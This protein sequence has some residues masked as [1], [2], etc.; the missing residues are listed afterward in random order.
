MR[1]NLIYAIHPCKNYPFSQ[2]SEKVDLTDA[3]RHPQAEQ[4]LRRLR[5]EQVS[6]LYHFTSIENLPCIRDMQVLCSKQ[7]LEDEDRWPPLVPGGDAL[8][9][10]LDRRHDNWGMVSCSFTPR[11]PMA[12][13]RK[14]NSHLCFFVVQIEVATFSGVFFTDIN[15]TANDHQRAEGIPGVNLIHFDVIQSFPR[16]WEREGW[17]RYVQAETLVPNC[18]PLD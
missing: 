11:T 17:F 9:H 10:S 8:S 12:Y 16:P 3:H 18:I 4:I 14:P 1:Y 2:P 5:Q 7:L 13:R 6:A 15:G